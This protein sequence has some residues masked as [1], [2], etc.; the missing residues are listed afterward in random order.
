MY[1]EGT[2]RFRRA[3]LGIDNFRHNLHMLIVTKRK[4]ELLM[5]D[6]PGIEQPSLT[7]NLLSSKELH[8]FALSLKVRKHP[9]WR[10]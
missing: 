10:Q 9:V 2:P 4:A 8:A 7:R 3:G 6:G 1:K 5:E